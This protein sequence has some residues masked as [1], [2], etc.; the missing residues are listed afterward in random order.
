MSMASR[1]Q[2]K[3]RDTKSRKVS[4]ASDKMSVGPATSK[5]GIPGFKAGGCMKKGGIPF[6]KDFEKDVKKKEERNVSKAF[7]A[8]GARFAKG[9]KVSGSAVNG[10]AQRGRTRGKMV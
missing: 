6:G 5:S 8:P 7:K 10:I 1:G 2:G 4:L 9:G 3:A